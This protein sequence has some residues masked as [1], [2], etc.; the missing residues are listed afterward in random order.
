MGNPKFE[1]MKPANQKAWL[2][3][4]EDLKRF[5]ARRDEIGEWYTLDYYFAEKRSAKG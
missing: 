3:W 1:D 5:R 4:K 2:E